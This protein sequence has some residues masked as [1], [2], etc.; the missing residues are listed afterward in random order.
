MIKGLHLLARAV[1]VVDKEGIIRYVEIV[2]ELTNE[3]DYK[4]AIE[5]VKELV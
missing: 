3:P 2:N 5:A 4:A 1:F